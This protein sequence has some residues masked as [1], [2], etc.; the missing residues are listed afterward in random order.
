[1]RGAGFGTTRMVS[2]MV[3]L[4][5]SYIGT[6]T[7]FTSVRLLFLATAIG[8]HKRRMSSASITRLNIVLECDTEIHTYRGSTLS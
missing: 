2:V 7:L 4:I 5:V 1:M 3:T 6:T 8:A